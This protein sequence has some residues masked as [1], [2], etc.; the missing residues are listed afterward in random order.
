MGENSVILSIESSCDDSS[1]AL[2]QINTARLLWQEKISQEKEHCSFGGVV[3][4][5][6]SRLHAV[7]LP[8]ILEN[9]L[10]FLENLDSI[11]SDS[12]KISQNTHTA[13]FAKIDSIESNPQNT[14][15]DSIES[16]K[17]ARKKALSKIAAIAITTE[18]G[19]NITLLEGAMMAKTLSAQIKK[20]L[21]SA[22]HL[23]GH[24]FSLFL[25]DARNEFQ[26]IFSQKAQNSATSIHNSPAQSPQNSATS[27]LLNEISPKNIESKKLENLEQNFDKKAIFPLLVLLV[28]GGHTMLIEC[29]SFGDFKVLGRSLDDSFGES[30]DKVAKMLSLG[31]PGGPIVENLAK[32]GSENAINFPLP[33]KDRRD[34]DFSFSGLKNAVRLA[35]LEHN[36]DSIK[37]P[38]SIESASAKNLENLKFS[39]NLCASFQSAAIKHLLDKCERLFSSN[40]GAKNTKNI[41]SKPED[42]I[43]NTI[44]AAPNIESENKIQQIRYFALVGG[45]SANLS[46]RQKLNKLCEKYNK[47]LLLAP[48][49]FCSD[50]AA[51][52]GR[53]GVEHYIRN[54]FKELNSLKTAPKVSEI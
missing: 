33:L 19:L 43:E 37:N 29:R 20:P 46:L 18:P 4:E 48:L 31:Y 17:I 13:D 27:S 41:E 22:N 52:I 11:E 39:Q 35:I 38:D 47:T 3:P 8:R 34:L 42:S 54:E 28:S 26:N 5:L 12:Y 51:M 16:K 49:E 25:S 23:R 14:Q 6:A 45:A 1:I 15:I 21:I 32:N 36:S 50:N 24:I 44:K 10:C 40:F 30:F 53:L 7:A 9:A 2:T